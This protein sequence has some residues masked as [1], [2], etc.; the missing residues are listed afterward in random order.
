MARKVTMKT[1]LGSVSR[2]EPDNTNY[3]HA[4][5]AS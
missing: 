5:V 1:C 4:L 3:E 2:Q